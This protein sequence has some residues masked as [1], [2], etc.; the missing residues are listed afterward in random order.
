MRKYCFEN[1][2]VIIKLIDL[3]CREHSDVIYL[4]NADSD[5]LDIE[6]NYRKNCYG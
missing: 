2:E 4:N 6:T 5:L 1:K 3:I